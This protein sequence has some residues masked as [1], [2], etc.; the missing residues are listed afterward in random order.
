MTMTIMNAVPTGAESQPE[1]DS[2]PPSLLGFF[3]VPKQG[4]TAH[5]Y[6]VRNEQALWATGARD[7]VASRDEQTDCCGSSWLVRQ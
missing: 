4:D 5:L 6:T 1:A 7:I 3:A 2:K